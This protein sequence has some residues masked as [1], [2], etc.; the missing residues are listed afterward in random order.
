MSKP[1]RMTE[2]VLSGFFVFPELAKLDVR[3]YASI[4]TRANT[5]DSYT[6]FNYFYLSSNEVQE[7]S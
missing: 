2:E 4:H 1:A 3:T 5:T 6:I 7:L